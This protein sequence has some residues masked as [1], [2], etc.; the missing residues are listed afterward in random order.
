MKVSIIVPALNEERLLPR[1]LESIRRQ[2]YTDYEV[3]VADAG[4]TDGTVQIAESFG[5]II[6]KGGLP[7][8]GRNA[9]ARAASGEYLFFFDADVELPDDFFE[10]AVAE[11]DGRYL[12]LATCEI[13]PLS[14]YVVDRLVH[15]FINVSVRATLRVDP[16]AMGFCIFVT[17][18]LF[19]RTGGFD[20]TV[21]VGEDAE[22]V[23]RAAKLSP[24][25][26]LS[27]VYISVSV[28]RFEK[29]GRLAHIKKGIKL[30]LHRAFKGEV[31]DD[32]IEYEF[33]NYDEGRDEYRT[34]LF[35]KIE[36]T[37]LKLEKRHESK[38]EPVHEA[39]LEE[40]E[41]V[42]KDFVRL[43]RRNQK[44]SSTGDDEAGSK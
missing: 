37:L 40:L 24:L 4:S 39:V 41:N 15:R 38:S 14:N 9:G 12:D 36:N 5:A 31:R 42:T 29:E 33:A 19:T 35:T 32:A 6:V 26:W 43:F 44:K 13:R 28:R 22:F 25:H 23:K 20:E 10:K 7:G 3:I 30:N 34:S 18:R 2:N 16:R 1:L 17:R 27:T 21:R 11:L 8:P